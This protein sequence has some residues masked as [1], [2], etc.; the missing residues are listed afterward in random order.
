ML[1]KWN[2]GIVRRCQQLAR[3]A[4]LML[5]TSNSVAGSQ[6]G[7]SAA[8]LTLLEAERIALAID[9]GVKQF[10][11][12][13][14]MIEQESIAASGW[15]DPKLSIGTM[16][17]PGN[18]LDP[19]NQGMFEF[20]VEQ[21]LPRG[22]SNGIQKRQLTLKKEAMDAAA[23]NH[24]LSVQ[25]DVRL[26]WLDVWYWQQALVALKA[27]RNLYESL[28]TVTASMYSQGRKRQQDVYNAK[29]AL[30]RLDDQTLSFSASYAESL[31]RLGRWLGETTVTKVG[32]DLPDLPE[33]RHE[34]AINAS[35]NHPMVHEAER[36]IDQAEQGVALA[37]ERFKPQFGVELAYGREQGDMAMMGSDGNRNKYSLMVM[38][39]LPLFT[40]NRQDRQLL[41]S[42]YRKEAALSVRQ[43]LLR[44]LT[45][46]LNAEV[47]RY[48]GLS[49]RLDHYS[50]NLLP[51]VES[52]S[53]AA[54]NA[55]QSD[56]QDFNSVIQSYRT[57][58][59][60]RLAFKRLQ[61]DIRQSLARI[62]YLM[63]GSS[64]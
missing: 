21:M 34:L 56:A 46:Q 17:L 6:A 61:A 53:Q 38:M 24:K 42:Q 44:Q 9:E 18:D 10:S 26:A 60:T 35:F 2:V 29:V 51:D 14:R 27:D 23:A 33:A 19:L 41:A 8:G 63:P 16:N 37:R 11:A 43:D 22:D 54:L 1:L 13:S 57:L 7:A 40:A 45:G 3:I 4:G 5:L 64:Y 12:Q 20:K 52:Q 31:A 47:A 50:N 15:M 30:S 59:D 28:V 25:R 48:R 58:L 39:D 49:Q 36:V 62:D 55:Y 32:S